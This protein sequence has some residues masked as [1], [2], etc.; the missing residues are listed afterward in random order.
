MNYTLNFYVGDCIDFEDDVIYNKS[1]TSIDNFNKSTVRFFKVE[2]FIV[3]FEFSLVEKMCDICVW[4]IVNELVDPSLTQVFLCDNLS[5]YDSLYIMSHNSES[6]GF[7]E[8]KKMFATSDG[9][10][11]DYEHFN[12]YLDTMY[13]E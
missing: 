10:L 13:I 5:E 12:A 3:D 9:E 7:C 11:H 2:H 6:V 4:K 8:L 1:I